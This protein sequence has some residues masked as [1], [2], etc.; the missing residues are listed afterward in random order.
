MKDQFSISQAYPVPA[1]DLWAA[2]TD[3]AMLAEVCRP[4]ITFEGLPEGRCQPGMEMDVKLRV[5]GVLPAQDYH[6]AIAHLDDAGMEV[7]SEERG[8][9]VK[10]WRHHIRVIETP[11]GS[12][13]T[14]TLEID[15]GLLTP[16]I[17]RWARIFYHHRHRR[18]LR[19]FARRSN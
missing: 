17:G 12:Q 11:D 13:L 1:A 14:D 4:L 5:F 7:Q 19:M 2:A 6:M 8:A 16:V 15:A 18:R 10:S 9:G 3:F